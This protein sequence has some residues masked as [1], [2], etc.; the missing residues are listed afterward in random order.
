MPQYVALQQKITLHRQ[1]A[2]SVLTD[3]KP[4]TLVIFAITTNTSGSRFR[5]EIQ[6]IR[7][8]LLLEGQ[9]W[10]HDGTDVEMIC[11]TAKNKC[12]VERKDLQ[13]YL[14][15]SRRKDPRFAPKNRD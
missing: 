15:K 4:H 2:L 6:G 12:L 9:L 3:L 5:T 1:S 7:R 10:C 14:V 11:C 13:A 8:K